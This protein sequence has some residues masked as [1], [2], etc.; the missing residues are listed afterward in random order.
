MLMNNIILKNNTMNSGLTFKFVN[1][2][3]FL[4]T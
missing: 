4:P 2:K 3:L 1:Y